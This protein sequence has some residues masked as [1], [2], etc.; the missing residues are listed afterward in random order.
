M[1]VMYLWLFKKKVSLYKS[2]CLLHALFFF[3]WTHFLP[4]HFIFPFTHFVKYTLRLPSP[5]FLWIC[6][7]LKKDSLTIYIEYFSHSTAELCFLHFIVLFYFLFF[8]CHLF[9]LF[10]GCF[11]VACFLN[12]SAN[13]LLGFLW[14]IK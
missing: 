3:P 8:L 9:S 1:N 11:Y 2:M 13:S 12:W 14:G 10:T 5:L 4:L 7:Y 6:F